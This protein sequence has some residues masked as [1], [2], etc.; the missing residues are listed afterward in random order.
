VTPGALTFTE[1]RV[2]VASASQ[3]VTV[4]NDGTALLHVT[5]V[6]ISQ[7]FQVSPSEPFDVPVGQSVPLSVTFKPTATGDFAGSTL[8]LT[9]DDPL[10]SS[11]VVNLSGKGVA[12]TLEPGIPSELTFGDQPLNS[13]SDPQLITVKNTGFG[14]LEVKDILIGVGTPFAVTPN[15]PFTLQQNESRQLSVTFHPKTQVLE[16]ATLSFKTNDTARPTV[17]VSL[18]GRG[19]YPKL[20]LSSSSLTFSRQPVGTP[21]TKTVLVRNDGTG[22]LRV[23]PLSISPKPPYMVS[24]ETPFDLPANQSRDLSVTFAPTSPGVYNG[25]LTLK[26]NAPDT[27]SAIINLSGNAVSTLEMTPTGTLDFG[28]VKVQSSKELS[29]TLKNTSSEDITLNSL[30]GIAPPF[31]IT[32]LTFPRVIT[33]TTPV[34]FK[35]LFSPGVYG[36]AP[37]TRMSLVSTADNSPHV[38][39]LVGVGEVPRALISLPPNTTKATSLDFGGVRLTTTRPV[40]VRVTNTGGAALVFNEPTIEPA[41]S[42]FSYSGPTTQTIE[43]GAFVE[44]QVSFTPADINSSAATLKLNSDAVDSPVPSLQLVG[45]GTYSEVQ[46]DRD[47]IFFGDVRV[48]DESDPPVAV[49]ISNPG[50]APLTVQSLSVTGP[51]LVENPTVADGGTSLPLTVPSNN[52]ATLNVRY[53]PTEALL[54][55]GAV[56]IRTDANRGGGATKPDGGMDAIGTVNVALQGNGTIAKLEMSATSIDFGTQRVNEISGAQPVIISNTG[57]ATLEI[58]QFLFN[59][60]FDISDA[61]TAPPF[62]ILPGKQKAVSLVFKPTTPG[63]TTGRL[64]I[65]SNAFEVPAPL[66]LSGTGV[67]GEILLDPAVVTFPTGVDVGGIGAQQTVLLKNKGGASLKIISVTQP[68]EPSFTVAGLSPNLVI[69]PNGQVQFTVNFAPTRRGF[70]SG[71]FVIETDTRINPIINLPLSGT[72]MAPAVVLDPKTP[73]NFGKSNVGVTVTQNI[74]VINQGEKALTV[75]SISFADETPDG[76]AAA[77]DFKT[78]VQ[79]FTVPAN[80]GSV[81]V[82]LKF[83]PQLVGQRQA[84]AIF[85]TNDKTVEAIL[86][87]EGTSPHL[88]LSEAAVNFTNVLVGS[89]SAP[90]AL[91]ITNTGSGPLTLSSLTIGGLDAAFFTMAPL[92]L[93][94]TLPAGVSTK[95]SLTFRPDDAR[96]FQGELVVVSNDTDVPTASVTLSGTGVRQQ[97]QLSESSLDFGQ[98]LLNNT[99]SLRKVRVTNSSDTNVTLSTLSVEGEGFAQSRVTL[100]L[101]L[102]PGQEQELGVSFTPL[103]ETEVTGK[104][105]VNFSDPPLSLEVA[106]RGRG[107]ASVLSVNPAPLQFGAVRVGGVKREQPFTLINL[108][109]ETIVLAPPEVLETTGEPFLYDASLISGRVLEPN[110]SIIVNVTYN[111]QVETLSETTLAFGTTTPQKPRAA[112]LALT[113]RATLRLLTADPESLDFGRVSVN[114]TVEPKLVTIVNK[115][116][117]QQ[118]V[119]VKLGNAEETHFTVLEAKALADPIPAG[120][121]ATFKVAFDPE[122]PGAAENQVQVFLQ[123]DTVPEAVITVKGHGQNLTGEGGGC[124]CNSGAGAAGMLALLALVGLG[125]RRRRRA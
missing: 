110:Q 67:D 113:G 80:N 23:T 30:S 68:A 78:D 72:G 29:V 31:S 51:F 108:S 42:P 75:S 119:V 92:Q 82:P 11:A 47:S 6:S 55:N 36:P 13:T 48:G 59:G 49:K 52:F 81:T 10:N 34:T 41:N 120:G 20:F 89:P 5:N 111:P 26:S 117:Q 69:S 44:F 77:L 123:G 32:G 61:G 56:T 24:P 106:L 19:V 7:H 125:S 103:S 109:S 94:L 2:N 53:K 64:F 66:E 54:Q 43:P 25:T 58:E 97:I 45:R 98:Q 102:R 17:S 90:R 3:P 105:K 124:S 38:L 91:T 88:L 28:N 112:T 1:Q 99:S 63:A 33:P 46:L 86:V 115:S 21:I 12:P 83:T 93:P 14:T 96:S 60:P 22:T 8:T 15:G 27:Q 76:S 37:T 16:T 114:K 95:V 101:V 79:P 100:P 107:I 85:S 73:L 74:S 62:D 71:S 116:A 57:K 121:S 70:L 84:R 50:T 118:R 104:L 9:T 65:V 39:D 18:S 4:K 35:I 122:A 40:Q 87:G